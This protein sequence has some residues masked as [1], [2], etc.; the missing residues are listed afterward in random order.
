MASTSQVD[1]QPVQK[2][3]KFSSMFD[4]VDEINA[5]RPSTVFQE[6]EECLKLPL[7][8]FSKQPLGFWEANEKTFPILAEL[9]SKF[10]VIPA[11]SGAIERLFSVAGALG[12][13]RRSRITVSLM[14]KC[15]MMRQHLV[16]SI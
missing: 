10:L 4:Y 3:K 11:T 7:Q 5:S 16:N 13:A 12:R 9:A 14:E 1:Y 6:I 2:K 15:L 8:P